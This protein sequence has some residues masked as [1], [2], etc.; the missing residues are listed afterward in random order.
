MGGRRDLKPGRFHSGTD[1][2]GLRGHFV[3][4]GLTPLRG[5][6]SFCYFFFGHAKKK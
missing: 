5:V 3:H 1:G 6:F 2:F 4:D